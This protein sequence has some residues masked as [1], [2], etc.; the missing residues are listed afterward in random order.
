[1]LERFHLI[2]FLLVL[3]LTSAEGSGAAP[4]DTLWNQA[5]DQGRKQG[6]WKKH[7]PNGELL[8]RG[9][10]RDDK[11]LG[12]MQRF[13]DN[14]NIKAELDYSG[15]S[16]TAC[17][18]MYFRN[19]QPGARGK[20]VN[21]ERD[22]VWSYYSYYT[23]TLSYQETYRMGRKNGPSTKF[24]PDGLKAEVLHWK[25]NM[26]HGTWKQFY[27]DSTLRLSSHYVMDQLNGTYTVYNRDQ[28]LVL[29]GTYK[30]GKMDGDWKFFNNEGNVKRVLSY[31]M[32][33]ILN[34][35][36]LGKWAEEYMKNVEK[37]LGKIPEPDFDNFFER[38]P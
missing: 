28:K 12:K 8:Y 31:R 26:K 21:R 32:G 37:D 11:P 33:N 20:Y 13:Y 25:D 10:F 22:S 36:E 3:V 1:M 17:A 30:N 23:G 38:N 4:P 5:D 29:D 2:C 9:F 24:Y 6:Y 19:G 15:N 7:Y 35:E 27:E 16:G 34:E 18:T 14:G